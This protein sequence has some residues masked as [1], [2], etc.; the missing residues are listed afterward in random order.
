MTNRSEIKDPMEGQS[1]LVKWKYARP[2]SLVEDEANAFN[3][4]SGLLATKEKKKKPPAPITHITEAPNVD[5]H[6]KKEIPTSYFQSIIHLFKGNIGPGLFAMGFAFMHG[7][8][9]LAP[10]LTV[11]IALISI[12]CQHMLINS[13]VKMKELRNSEKYPDF[14]E[15]IEQCFETGPKATQKLARTMKGLVN[16]FICV[17]QLGFCCIYFVFIST[18]IKQILLAYE[19]NLDVHYVML[20]TFIPIWLSSM[21]TNLKYLTPV[22]FIANICMICGLSITMYYGL[23]DGLPDVAERKL[24]TSPMELA[25]YFG[26]AIFAF[27][28][29]AL[30]LPLKN[31][32]ANPNNFDRPMGVLNVGMFFVTLMFM[33]AGMV[34]YIKWGD[35]VAGS[36]TLNL[37]DT[38]GAQIVKVMVSMGVL[39]GYPLQFHIAIQIMLPSVIETFKCYEHTLA[40]NLTFR[41]VMVIVTLGIAE[42]VPN[43]GLFISLIGSLCSTAL[44]LVFPPIIELIVKRDISSI[45]ARYSM[46]LKNAI[47]LILAMAGF[48]AGTYE[49]LSEIIKEFSS[50]EPEMPTTPAEWT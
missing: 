40:A 50:K 4:K 2:T 16:L 9:V 14:A 27:E 38:I 20:I 7:G 13:S 28:G 3:S 25:L 29:I 21:I 18:N 17:T 8:L 23:K 19:I 44:A 35:D 47:I 49:S 36:L 15:T 42:L 12:H 48:V 30:V 22:S 33:A 6:I 45:C 10:I 11:L 41:S 37:G 43:L 1:L 5:D 34:G 32:M 24:F 26:T 31:A 39:F 46:Y